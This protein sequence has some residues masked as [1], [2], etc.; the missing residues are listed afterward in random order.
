MLNIS[1]FTLAHLKLLLF[2]ILACSDG[3]VMLV[4]GTDDAEGT[5]QICYRN[6]Y[7]TV[8]DDWWD[9]LDAM[10]VCKQ[11]GFLEPGKL[12]LCLFSQLLCN[13]YAIFIFFSK[14]LFQ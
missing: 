12:L 14:L 6:A 5:I 1:F 9:T 4:G 13:F 2:N 7:G 8:C 3:N 10:V 11:L